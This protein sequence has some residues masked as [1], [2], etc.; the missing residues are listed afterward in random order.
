MGGITEFQ[1]SNLIAACR[2]H[3]VTGEHWR[4]SLQSFNSNYNPGRANLYQVNGCMFAIW[5]IS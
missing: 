5:S 1:I 2:A 3:E 4:A